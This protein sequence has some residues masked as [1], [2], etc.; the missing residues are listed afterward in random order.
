MLER[1]DVRLDLACE[2]P[3]DAVE[4]QLFLVGVIHAANPSA[5]GH[6]I[7]AHHSIREVGE[8][9]AV[10]RTP[11]GRL[12]KWQIAAGGSE[13]GKASFPLGDNW[14]GRGKRSRTW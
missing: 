9:G 5:V 2:K 6:S 4:D 11:G 1:L 7:S 12:Q 10:G 3:R 13:C 8:H 14:L